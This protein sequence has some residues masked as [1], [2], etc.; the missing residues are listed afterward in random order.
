M[1]MIEKA[2]HG[3]FGPKVDLGPVD[4]QK[5]SLAEHKSRKGNFLVLHCASPS[6]HTIATS[7]MAVISYGRRKRDNYGSFYSPIAFN[8]DSDNSTR[9]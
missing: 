5:S 1:F 7:K 9:I 4:R 6:A 2:I 8:S 3:K